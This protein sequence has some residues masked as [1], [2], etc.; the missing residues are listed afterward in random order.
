MTTS[1]RVS[2]RLKLRHKEPLGSTHPGVE[3]Y[4][5]SIAR[6]PGSGATYGKPDSFILRGVA[7]ICLSKHRLEAIAGDA[8]GSRSSLSCGLPGD[9]VVMNPR[10]TSR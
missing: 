8:C 10:P 2:A 4:N 1:D 5:R 9:L 7:G 3:P 6:T